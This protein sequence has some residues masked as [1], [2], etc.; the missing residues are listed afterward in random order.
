LTAGA[1]EGLAWYSLQIGREDLERRHSAFDFTK[2]LHDSPM[3]ALIE[4]LDLVVSVDTAVAHL[5]GALG[6]PVW[7][8]PAACGL[9][10]EVDGRSSP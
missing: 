9:A 3:A 2:Q 8:P 4:Q 5:A 1:A 10:L 6:R 7:V